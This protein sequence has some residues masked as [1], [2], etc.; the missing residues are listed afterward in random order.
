M[1]ELILPPGDWAGY[2]FDCDGTLV[3]SMPLH[4]KA[5][6]AALE[7]HGFP[8]E[9]FTLQMHH[10]F[11]GMPGT[12]IVERMNRDF[13]CA[14]PP[15][16]VE[17]DKVVWYLA[18]HHDVRGIEPVI[19]IARAARGRLP[20]SVASGSDAHIVHDSLKAAGI[21]DLFL[22]VVTPVDVARGKPAPDMFLLCAERMGVPP[23]KC[24]VF[25]DGHLGLQA[26]EAAGM[27][28]VFVSTEFSAGE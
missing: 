18:H 17:A 13:G 10:D 27:G 24:L 26:A 16:Q 28:T 12:A 1:P 4:L 22:T 2:I 15:E 20:M 6:R 3:D 8:P 19:A 11:A 25:E 5:W 7:K 23:E 14:L 9:K 21:H